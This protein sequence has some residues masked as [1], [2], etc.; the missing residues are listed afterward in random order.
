M[1]KLAKKYKKTSSRIVDAQGI[2]A[3]SY[4]RDIRVKCQQDG[5]EKYSLHRLD[6]KY[7]QK[8]KC[9]TI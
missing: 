9:H 7:F 3:R 4:V 8:R 2:S 1:E 5:L 6:I